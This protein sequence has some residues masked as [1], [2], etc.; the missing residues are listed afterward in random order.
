MKQKN[1]IEK[2]K[3]L[4]NTAKNKKSE[5]EFLK[6][7]FKNEDS[8]PQGDGVSTLLSIFIFKF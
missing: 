5:N 4:I 7:I 6:H 3:A 2:F 1:I 8:P